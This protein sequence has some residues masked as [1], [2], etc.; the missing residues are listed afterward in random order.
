MLFVVVQS[1]SCVRLL[2]NPWTA[3]CHAS[4]SFTISQSLLKLMSTELVMSSHAFAFNLFKSFNSNWFYY[5]QHIFACCF[6]S[7]D[8]LWLLFNL[9]WP[10]AFNIIDMVKLKFTILLVIFIPFFVPFFPYMLVDYFLISILLNSFTELFFLPHLKNIFLL[11]YH[12]QCVCVCSVVSNSLWPHG[13][14]PPGSS[15]HGIFPARILKWVAVSSSRE[16]F[17]PWDQICIFCIS[18]IDRQIL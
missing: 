7:S 1:L 15:V 2:V 8:N 16:S 10:F 17:L 5:N 9:L 11:S 12:W 14:C 13:L 6:F 3:A 4:L 18:C